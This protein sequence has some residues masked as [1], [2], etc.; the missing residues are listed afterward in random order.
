MP[1]LTTGTWLAI[2]TPLLRDSYLEYR[3]DEA[4]LEMAREWGDPI[5]LVI[6]ETR[7]GRARWFLMGSTLGFATGLG[8]VLRNLKM[9]GADRVTQGMTSVLSFLLIFMFLAFWRAKR[10]DRSIRRRVRRVRNRCEE[11]ERETDGR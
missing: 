7:F 11:L 8:A 6:A 3:E 5:K 9:K 1:W 2:A 10:Q 4:E